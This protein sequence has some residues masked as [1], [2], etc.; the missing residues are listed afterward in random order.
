MLFT[1]L[2][3]IIIHRAA[4]RGQYKL[5]CPSARDGKL[6][7]E[8]FLEAQLYKEQHTAG[9]I[10]S[11]VRDLLQELVQRQSIELTALSQRH[12]TELSSLAVRHVP[13]PMR[14]HLACTG[15]LP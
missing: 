6:L 15:F 10:A 1:A 11:S 7:V 4:A 5:L 12:T 9:A 3:L 8:K 14:T 2:M 13:P